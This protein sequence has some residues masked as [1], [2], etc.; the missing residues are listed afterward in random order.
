MPEE[1][2]LFDLLKRGYIDTHYKG[3]YEITAEELTTLIER[4]GK[5]QVIA[6]RLCQEKI[7]S[8]DQLTV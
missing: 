7:A 3:H 5:L 6:E 1:K 2:H 8:F 4:V